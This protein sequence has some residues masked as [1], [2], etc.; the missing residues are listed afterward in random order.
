[1]V[2][3]KCGNI[4]GNESTG[5]FAELNHP[6]TGFLSL[7]NHRHFKFHTH[8]PIHLRKKNR[9]R[10]LDE[11]IICPSALVGFCVTEI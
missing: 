7:H 8:Q 2:Q 6:R 9:N 5:T 1:M 11:R 4:L 3:E 10:H